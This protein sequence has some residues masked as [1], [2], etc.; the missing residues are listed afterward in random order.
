MGTKVPVYDFKCNGCGH[1]FERNVPV[2][3]RDNF[4]I[5]M[6]CGGGMTRQFGVGGVYIR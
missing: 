1:T 6:V 3:Q 5:C 2:E 4:I